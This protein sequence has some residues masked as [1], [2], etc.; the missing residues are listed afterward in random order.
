MA[1]VWCRREELFLNNEEYL[2]FQFFLMPLL[3]LPTVQLADH[4][5]VHV[6]GLS[7]LSNIPW[8]TPTLFDSSWT[9]SPLFLNNYLWS[10]PTY[11]KTVTTERVCY[12]LGFTRFRLMETCAIIKLILWLLCTTLSVASLTLYIN[13]NL[14]HI[15]LINFL[16][17]FVG[18]FVCLPV[19][20]SSSDYHLLILNGVEWTLLAGWLSWVPFL[21]NSYS[22]V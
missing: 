16:D 3:N 4:K 17:M 1:N 18:L 22:I 2:V 11:T 13:S 14:S 15:R 20:L 5:Y 12:Q 19:H 21:F 8:G 10:T 9:P 6:V 7:S